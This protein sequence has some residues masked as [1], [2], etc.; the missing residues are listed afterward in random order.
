MTPENKCLVCN[1]NNIAFRLGCKDHL[2][3]DEN[4]DI[5][6]C[7]SCGFL[8]T[9]NPP[10]EKEIGKYYD[11]GDYI[12]HSDTKKGFTN[13]LFHFTRDLMLY[14]KRSLINK[15]TGLKTGSLLDIGCGTGY[16]AG[17]MKK[18]GW[19]VTGLEKNERARNFAFKKFNLEV[20]E[21]TDLEKCKDNHF[22][23]ITLWHVFEHF[24]NP[25]NYMAV[26]KRLLKPGGLCIAAMPNCSS[27]DAQHYGKYW[28]AWDVPRHLW[29]FT[30]S[31]FRDFTDKNGFEITKIRSLPADVFY[32]SILSEKY[33]GANLPFMT[34]II[35]SIWFAVFSLFSKNRSSSLIYLLKRKAD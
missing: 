12:S 16:F 15:A 4:F 17:F 11:T 20:L 34:G 14:R 8:F 32:I 26:I 33:R 6:A 18:A 31:T 5:Y 19:I 23:C 9:I 24:H 25:V 2:T 28:A 21:D 1:S 22:D 30:P 27:F 29:H 35:K 7:K 3:G 13:T 10:S